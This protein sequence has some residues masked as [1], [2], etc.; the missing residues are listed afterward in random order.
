MRTSSLS[1]SLPSK[2]QP[3]SRHTVENEHHVFVI[4]SEIKALAEVH[5]ILS[6]EVTAPAGEQKAH[7]SAQLAEMSVLL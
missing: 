3:A 7:M 1:S 4:T 5:G 6:S 2:S